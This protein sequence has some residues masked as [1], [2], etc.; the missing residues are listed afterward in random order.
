MNSD[1]YAPFININVKIICYEPRYKFI[2]SFKNFDMEKY[3]MD[4]SRIP[5]LILST[6]DDPGKQLNTFNKLSL[7]GIDENATLKRVKMT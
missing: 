6:R 7:S 1:R 3:K 4:V 5:F 2:R